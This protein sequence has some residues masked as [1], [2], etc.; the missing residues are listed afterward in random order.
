MQLQTK[1]IREWLCACI[2]S[3]RIPEQNRANAAE[4]ARRVNIS[5]NM[6]GWLA[7]SRILN[8]RRVGTCSMKLPR[9]IKMQNG[10]DQC[11]SLARRGATRCTGSLGFRVTGNF[12]PLSRR[13]CTRGTEVRRGDWENRRQ[14]GRRRGEARRRDATRR[15][16]KAEG[17]ATSTTKPT[18]T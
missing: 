10:G 17:S 3:H 7:W 14:R 2:I 5:R 15:A 11:V 18:T 6:P 1:R 16:R 9:S 12:V 4:N 13:E 8:V